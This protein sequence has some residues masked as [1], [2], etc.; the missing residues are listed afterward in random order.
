MIYFNC[1]QGTDFLSDK[2]AL[3]R[4]RSLT[5]SC[6]P[7]NRAF[8]L[9]DN[10][11]RCKQCNK[12]L[13]NKNSNAIWCNENC[14]SKFRWNNV[15]GYKDHCLQRSKISYQK[16]KQRYKEKYQQRQKRL[17]RYDL[18]HEDFLKLLA[19]QEYKCSIC[20]REEK[21]LSIRLSIDHDHKTNKVRGLLCNRCNSMLG[22]AQDSEK[23]LYKAIQYLRKHKQKGEQN[24]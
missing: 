10:M 15:Q 12:E 21:S 6:E 14:R 9:E 23:I 4:R 18:S 20:L 2:P 7:L 24:D 1:S 16:N 13:L 11:P 22:L 17:I 5:V 3:S 8:L 19:S